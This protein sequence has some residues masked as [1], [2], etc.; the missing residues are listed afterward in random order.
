MKTE[1]QAQAILRFMQQG[2]EVTPMDALMRFKCMRLASRIRDIKDSGIDI[3]DR[4]IVRDD[5]KR[6]KAYSVK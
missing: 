4:W 2:Y 1:S 3:A 6:F 5:G